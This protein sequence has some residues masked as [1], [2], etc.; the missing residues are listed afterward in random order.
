MQITLN[1]IDFL[2]MSQE[3]LWLKEKEGMYPPRFLVDIDGTSTTQKSQAQ[4]HFTG[5]TKD[6]FLVCTILLVPPPQ[7]TQKA[8]HVMNNS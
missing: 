5:T 2:Q 4:I 1:D 8:V 6:E 7:G 3:E